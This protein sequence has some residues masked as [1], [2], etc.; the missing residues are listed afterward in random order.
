MPGEKLEN[1]RDIIGFCIVKSMLAGAKH[2]EAAQA[3]AYFF[4][5]VV[6]LVEWLRLSLSRRVGHF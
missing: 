3:I 4:M 2:R 6:V 1:A 5:N